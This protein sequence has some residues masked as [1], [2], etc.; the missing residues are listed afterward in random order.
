MIESAL[1]MDCLTLAPVTPKMVARR[2][3]PSSLCPNVH[4]RSAF[5]ESFEP[6]YSGAASR[7][8]SG[9]RTCDSP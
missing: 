6:V 8:C 7:Q 2:F 1:E 9:R 3:P 5:H 4:I